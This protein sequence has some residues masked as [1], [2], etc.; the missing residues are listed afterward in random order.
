MNTKRIF[1]SAIIAA[2]PFGAMAATNIFDILYNINS[3]GVSGITD[4]TTVNMVQGGPGLP[5]PLYSTTSPSAGDESH[6]ATTAYVKGAFN[7][8]I[9][10]INRLTAGV[11]HIYEE[12]RGKQ[13]EMGL[14]DSEE[15]DVVEFIETGVRTS[16]DEVTT[17]NQLVNGMAVKNALNAKRV[18]IY[19]TW[20]DDTAAAT[21]LVPF[22]TAQ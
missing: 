12:V 17:A 10:I 22:E 19:T 11:S 5:I 1:L 16:L 4:S 18:R 15:E 21:T 20:D 14:Y 3:V 8:T 6:I 7:D 13:S 9:A 2:L